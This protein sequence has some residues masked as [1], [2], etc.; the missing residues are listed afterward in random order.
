MIILLFAGSIVFTFTYGPSKRTYVTPNR[1]VSAQSASAVDALWHSSGVHGRIAIIFARHLNQQ[2]SGKGFPE[3]DYID[4]AMRHGLVRSVYYIVPDS[5]WSEVATENISNPQLLA[6]IKTTDNGFML[7]HEGGRIHVMPLSKYIP[8]QE[9]EKALVV[10]ERRVWSRQEH[11]R[12]NNH[13]KSGL[14]TTD[15]LIFIADKTKEPPRE[16]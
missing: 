13:L 5:A 7:L 14:L 12:I 9:K 15:F 6:P 10:I 2:F 8:E 4:R 1:T 16:N 11:F 3:M